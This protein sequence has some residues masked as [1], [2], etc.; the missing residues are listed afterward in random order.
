MHTSLL[1]FG[2]VVQHLKV[3]FAS[4]CHVYVVH[5]RNWVKKNIYTHACTHIQAHSTVHHMNENKSY[6]L[7]LLLLTI[8]CLWNSARISNWSAGFVSIYRIYI[9]ILLHLLKDRCRIMDKW[10]THVRSAMQTSLWMS[11]K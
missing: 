6:I 1:S 7:L 5:S 2:F 9:T 10:H 4:L 3:D 8:Y 11:R